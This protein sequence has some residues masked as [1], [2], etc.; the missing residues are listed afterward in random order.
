LRWFGILLARYRCLVVLASRLSGGLGVL[1]AQSWSC[2][3][4]S[5]WSLRFHVM[6][7]C[8]LG[9]LASCVQPCCLVLLATHVLR[10]S[11]ST[12]C[13][14]MSRSRTPL[15]CSGGAIMAHSRYRFISWHEGLQKW[16]AQVKRRKKTWY[17]AFSEEVDAIDFV[18]RMTG[19]SKLALL[20]QP[21]RARAFLSRYRGVCWHRG[22]QKWIIQHAVK[23]LGAYLT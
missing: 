4:P 14:L 16:V 21:P 18:V 13:I 10:R 19:R 8:C 6:L 15:P 9:V 7:S 23:T 20:R 22:N 17:K 2:L 1:I 11:G 12:V 3:L 5:L